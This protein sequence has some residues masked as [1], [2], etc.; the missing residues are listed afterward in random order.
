MNH[1]SSFI[2]PSEF[3][4]GCKQTDG[5]FNHNSFYFK[6]H[7]C[8]NDYYKMYIICIGYYHRSLHQISMIDDKSITTFLTD[9]SLFFFI[10]A[11]REKYMDIHRLKYLSLS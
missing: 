7:V 5:L 11:F 1:F 6:T 2:Q 10:Q 8:F 9:L 4:V 3:P